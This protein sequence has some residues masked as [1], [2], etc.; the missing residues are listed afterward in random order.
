MLEMELNLNSL[1]L[2]I[3]AYL[4]DPHSLPSKYLIE[5]SLYVW[6]VPVSMKMTELKLESL[7]SFKNRN[8]MPVSGDQTLN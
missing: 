5:F 4:F 1:Q 6:P 8:S 7:A 3:R 2:F